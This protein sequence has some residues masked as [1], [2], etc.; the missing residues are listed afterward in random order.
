MQVRE[1][2]FPGV[3]L[4]VRSEPSRVGCRTTEWVRSLTRTGREAESGGEERRP[5]TGRPG[6]DL[7][8]CAVPRERAVLRAGSCSA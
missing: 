3:R 7:S 6:I 5:V 4:C 2:H 1:E 8:F